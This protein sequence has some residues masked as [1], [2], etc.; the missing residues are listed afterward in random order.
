LDIFIGGEIDLVGIFG[1]ELGGG[2]IIDLDT[3]FDSGIYL[4]TA[5]AGGLNVGVGVGGGVVINGDLEGRALALDGNILG[6]SGV[7]GVGEDGGVLVGGSVGPGIGGSV[8]GGQT[9]SLS[10]QNVIDFFRWLF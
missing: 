2:I 5:V 6:G 3:P 10:I 7:I 9:S 8:S 4:S 1:I